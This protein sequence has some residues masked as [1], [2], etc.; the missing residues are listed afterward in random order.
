MNDYLATNKGLDARDATSI[1]LG[2]S[3]GGF[4]GMVF[5]GILG[6]KAYNESPRTFCNSMAIMV[7]LGGLPWLYLVSTDNYNDSFLNMATHITIAAIAGILCTIPR[8][9]RRDGHP[10]QIY[11]DQRG[12]AFSSST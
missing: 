5:G 1:M 6:Q 7:V 10:R 11:R 2:F 8:E 12:A 9:R 4:L 3:L